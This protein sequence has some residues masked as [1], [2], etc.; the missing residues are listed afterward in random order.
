MAAHAIAATVRHETMTPLEL[1][2]AYA[3]AKSRQDGAAALALCTDD[4]VL[5]TVPFGIRGAGNADVATQLGLFFETFPDYRVTIEGQAVAEDGAAVSCWGTWHATMRGALGTFAATQAAC[6][7]PFV[8]VFEVVGSRLAAERFFFD[9]GTLCVQLGLPLDRVAGELRA[10]AAV[11]PATPSPTAFWPLPG[12]AATAAAAAAPPGVRDPAADFVARFADFW[13][14]PVDL[15][16]LETLLHPDSRLVAPGMPTTVGRAAGIEAFRSVFMLV[17]DLHID[18]VRWRGG[19]D[20]VFIETIMRGTMNGHT[21]EI[22]AVDRI[23]IRDGMVLERIAY[24]DAA[25]MQ[26]AMAGGA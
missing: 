14:P 12:E 2:S 1:V 21:L 10:F 11:H 19:G 7:V 20:V 4:F 5:D 23:T 26:A 24:F 13:R 9:L 3:A 25:S 6:T 15:R 18:V 16:V 22:P 8:C 17:P